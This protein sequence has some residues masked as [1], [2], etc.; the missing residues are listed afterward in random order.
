MRIS[1]FASNH[2]PVQKIGHVLLSAFFVDVPPAS[3]A[4]GEVCDHHPP[5]TVRQVEPL[6]WCDFL[7]P[8]VAWCAGTGELSNRRGGERVHDIQKNKTRSC[9]L[10]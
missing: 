5:S 6:I 10:L 9:R 2:S 7:D 1:E 4:G 3:T 8:K